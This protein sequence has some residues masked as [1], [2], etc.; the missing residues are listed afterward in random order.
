MIKKEQ[1]EFAKIVVKDQVFKVN[2]S[3]QMSQSGKN[4]LTKDP[5][6]NAANPKHFIPMM[7]EDR[8]GERSDAF[9]KII[10]ATHKHFWDPLDKKYIANSCYC[11]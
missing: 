4:S 1:I 10:S 7:D 2:K 8:Y 6:Y 3:Y 5:A 11:R 9:D